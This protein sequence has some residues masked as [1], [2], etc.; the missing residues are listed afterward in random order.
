MLQKA[1]KLTAGF[2][3]LRFLTEQENVV[4]QVPG[5][6]VF[7]GEQKQL[8][9]TIHLI[10][11][12]QDSFVEADLT[13]ISEIETYKKEFQNI[14]INIDGLHNIDKI[15]QVG[16]YYKLHPL[17]QE[18]I[19]HTGQRAKADVEDEYLFFI[20][21]MMKLNKQNFQLDAEQFSMYLDGNVL[22]TFQEIHGDV[23]E[24]IRNRIRKKLGR[25]RNKKL[26]YLAY[27]LLD[28]IVDN[29]NNIMEYFG[30]QIEELEDKILKQP[31]TDVLQE[32][33][34]Y[35]IE[36]NFFRKSIRPAREAILDINTEDVEL[37]SEDIEPFYDDL[38]DLITRAYET[39]DSYKN[40][41]SEQLTIYSI[42]VNNK[43]ND[44]M[45]VLTIFSAVFIPLTFIAGIYGTNFEHVPELHYKYSYFIMWGVMVVIAIGMLA[46]FKHKKW[47]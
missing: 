44:I 21:K 43:M 9:T 24:P 26:D 4:G 36:L 5:K 31:S 41:L 46:Y 6:L 12:N 25:V 2:K 16:K 13:D 7:V 19:V 8:H 10:A 20:M 28:A 47:F 30:Y 27:C 40:M 1:K 45:K 15:R 32:I 3:K 33:N 11:Y 37:I 18:D 42:N 38:S 29:Y 14:W 34:G 23:F 39:V 35:K 22:L 17:L